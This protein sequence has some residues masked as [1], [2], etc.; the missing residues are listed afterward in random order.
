VICAVF[1]TSIVFACFLWYK[2]EWDFIHAL[3]IAVGFFFGFIFYAYGVSFLLSVYPWLDAFYFY[4]IW[5]AFQ[6]VGSGIASAIPL[7]LHE[8]YEDAWDA[9][10]IWLL[11]GFIYVLADLGIGAGPPAL[12]PYSPYRDRGTLIGLN[13]ACFAEDIPIGVLLEKVGVNP[14]TDVAVLWGYYVI[15]IIMVI[16]LIAVVGFKKVENLIFQEIPD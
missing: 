8:E 3:S 13:P 1:V 4:F 15:P 2:G 11:F 6:W 10:Q 7:L 12:G 16:L 9:I 14:F 5:F